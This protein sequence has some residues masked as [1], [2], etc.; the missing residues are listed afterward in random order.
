[1]RLVLCHFFFFPKQSEGGGEEVLKTAQ[2]A[3]AFEKTTLSVCRGKG[4]AAVESG[5]GG[6][7]VFLR[8]DWAS[9]D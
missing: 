2:M 5:E 8:S 7:G 1:M 3:F 4:G 6:D 9:E